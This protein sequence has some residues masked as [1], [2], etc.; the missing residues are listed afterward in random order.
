MQNLLVD[1]KD[2][3]FEIMD[4]EYD[5]NAASISALVDLKSPLADVPL[6]NLHRALAYHLISVGRLSK[7]VKDMI[8][9]LHKM[10]SYPPLYCEEIEAVHKKIAL[11]LAFHLPMV[12]FYSYPY[13]AAILTSDDLEIIKQ[14][15]DPDGDGVSEEILA[16]AEDQINLPRTIDP[17]MA[18]LNI[19][20]VECSHVQDS[21][22]DFINLE[23]EDIYTNFKVFN[24]LQSRIIETSKTALNL[25]LL[26]TLLKKNFLDPE[27]YDY[28]RSETEE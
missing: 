1:L 2:I 3:I 19:L 15:D 24:L 7:E 22:E 12:S 9:E 17:I 6:D 11:D 28:Y 8:I 26:L 18:N 13:N 4:G 25:N 5:V 23:D 27:S 16:E 21:L 10:V 14:N 20:A